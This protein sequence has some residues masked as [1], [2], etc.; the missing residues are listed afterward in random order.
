MGCHGETNERRSCARA[1][2]LAF[3]KFANFGKLVKV[4]TKFTT[5]GHAGGA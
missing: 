3:T 1:L 5:Q 4:R 2:F